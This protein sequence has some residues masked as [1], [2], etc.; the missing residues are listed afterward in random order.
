MTKFFGKLK[1]WH[2]AFLLL[3][4]VVFFVLLFPTSGEWLGFVSQF[5]NRVVG[6]LFSAIPFSVMTVA[7][8]LLPVFVALVIW[9]VVVNKKRKT[10]AKFF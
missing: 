9:R 10:M 6:G 7:I 4:V 1:I 2:E 8:L 5:A 3:G